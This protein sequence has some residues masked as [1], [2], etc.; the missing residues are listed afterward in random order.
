MIIFFTREPAVLCSTEG[1]EKESGGREKEEGRER[2]RG[3]KKKVC[4][5]RGKRREKKIRRMMEDE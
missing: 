1:E 4:G 2:G 3:G 5:R